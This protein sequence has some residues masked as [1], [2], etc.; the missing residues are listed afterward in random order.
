MEQW[1]VGQ[2]K[3]LEHLEESHSS[4]PNF[5]GG[6]RGREGGGQGTKQEDS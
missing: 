1:E 3:E 5:T 6:M 2:A 4:L